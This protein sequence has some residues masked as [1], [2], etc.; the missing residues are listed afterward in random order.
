MAEHKQ[1]MVISRATSGFIGFWHTHP[2]MS[3]HQSTTDLAG[4][5]QLV[6][7]V[8]QNQKRALML[9]FGRTDERPSAGVYVY[10]SPGMTEKGDLVVAGTSQITL[11]TAVV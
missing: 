8:G 3:S 6:S 11:E 2:D 5:A 1:R 4:M 10:E 9:I 7:T